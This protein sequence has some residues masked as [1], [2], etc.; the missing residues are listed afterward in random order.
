MASLVTGVLTYIML[1]MCASMATPDGYANWTEYLMSLKELK[2]VIALPTFYSAQQSMGT[3]GLVTL[4]IAA[5]CGIITALIANNIALSRLFYSMSGDGMAP[6]RL[7]RLN[8][9]GIPATAVFVVT[10]VSTV[11][12]LLGRTAIGWIVDVTTIG[13]AIIYAYTSIASFVTGLR[14][15]H[16]RVQVF[17]VLGTLL[18]MVFVVF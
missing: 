14:E 11:I 6:K 12:P 5:L 3:I 8:G 4:G 13:A 18:A 16:R 7:G 15:K 9:K 1:V 2:G 17:G 10:G